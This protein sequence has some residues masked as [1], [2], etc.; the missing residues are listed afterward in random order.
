MN[1]H[2]AVLMGGW[3]AEREIS[4]RSGRACA[5]ALVRLDYRVTRAAAGTV[6]LGMAAAGGRSASV[7]ITG[8]LRAAGSDWTELAVPLRC[9]ADQGVEMA[10]VTRP[11]VIAATGAAGIDV[12][13][14]RIAS[15]PPGPVSCGQR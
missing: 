13:G 15:A 14:I 4:L 2:I 3:S 6:T 11:A 10:K 12:S 9:F 1:K 7:P 5:D 8:A